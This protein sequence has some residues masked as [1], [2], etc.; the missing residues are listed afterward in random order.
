M[1]GSAKTFLDSALTGKVQSAYLLI[2]NRPGVS[3][4]L[5]DT[6]LMRLLCK[7]GG[8]GI[9]PECRRVLEGH[10][11][12]MRLSAPKVASIRE[13]ISFVSEKPSG[14]YKAVVIENADDMTPSAANSLLKTL[15]QPPQNTVFI[16]QARSASGVL[17]T[18]LSRCAVVHITPGLDAQGLIGRELKVNASTAHILCDL[19]GGFLEEAKAIYGDADFWNARPLMLDIC[20]KLLYQKGMAIS[21][22]ADFLETNKERLGALLCVMQSYFRDILIYSKTKDNRLLI[23]TDREAEIVSASSD[24]TSGAI[25]NIINS[26]FET[27]RRFFFSVNFKL[28]IE[29][30]FFDILEEKARWKKL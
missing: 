16:L 24:F 17:P 23:N 8:C 22:M 13:V 4:K 7:K 14:L 11:D 6:F 29:K 21:S 26:I 9:C 27:E 2:C 12:I 19:S 28:A 20:H 10:I 15:E 25:S 5:A 1:N 30:L 3:A 18:V